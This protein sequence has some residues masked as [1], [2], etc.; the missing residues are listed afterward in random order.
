[1]LA[2]GTVND[3]G[4]VWRPERQ[5]Y[6]H[7]LGVDWD[8]SYARK[9]EPPV[10]SWPY[11]TVA[12]VPA[13][14]YQRITGKLASPSTDVD[15]IYFEI[16]AALRRRGQVILYGPPGTGKT[17][18]ARRAA[19]WLLEGGSSNPAAAAPLHDSDQFHGQEKALSGKADGVVL[20][21]VT[22][23]PSYTYEDFV[24]GYRPQPGLDAGLHLAMADG[25]FKRICNAARLDPRL[26][27]LLIDEIN[28]G[29]VP[30]NPGRVDHAH[31]EGQTG[32]H[33]PA[34]AEQRGVHRT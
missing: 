25:L 34:G 9:L 17:Y 33:G 10:K 14:L 8:D 29:N 22:F 11:V 20:T 30:K 21:R 27:V 2:I 6:R 15:P 28:R 26:H 12:K 5:E 1:V 4:Y 16:E 18:T 23:H 3:D 7:T 19:V 32:S 24:E 13:T 31:R